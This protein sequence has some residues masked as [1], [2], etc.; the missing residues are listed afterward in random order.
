LQLVG[1]DEAQVL[2][3]DPGKTY[4]CRNAL[5]VEYSATDLSVSEAEKQ[6]YA[7]VADACRR[8]SADT[9]GQRIFLSR[10]TWSPKHG[11]RRVLQN[12]R[13]LIAS[14]GELGFQAVHP[15]RL[16]VKE[17]IAMFARAKCVVAL[18]G[19]ALFSVRFCPPGTTIVY[20]EASEL[21]LGIHSAMLSSGGHR[22]GVIVGQ[23][24]LADPEPVHKRWTIDVQLARAAIQEVL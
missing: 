12:E 21:F 16:P 13:E 14:L 4:F 15:E 1:I 7:D 22:F 3:H 8:E 10:L 2:E 17:Q 11:Q 24:D 19:S 23:Q 18:G 5:T 6:V 9:F 20:I